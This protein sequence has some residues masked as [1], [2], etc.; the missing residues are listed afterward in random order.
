[1]RSID[2]NIVVRLLLRDDPAQVALVDA[3]VAE[4][5]LIVS[6]TV[7]IETEWVLRA[8]YRLDRPTVSR[9]LTLLVDIEGVDVP[10]P[11]GVRWALGRH[12]AGADLADMIHLIVTESD[13][14][15]TLDQRLAS[16]AGSSPRQP[17]TVLR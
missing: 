12:A 11:P 5:G 14:F 2:T 3:L 13:A 17:V 1:M 10:D 9:L 15:V 8:V 6:P 4:G 16:D 7:L